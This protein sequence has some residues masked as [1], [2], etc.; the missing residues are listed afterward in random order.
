MDRWLVGLVCSCVIF[1]IVMIDSA[2]SVW[3]L[4]R[5]GD[6]HFFSKRQ[7]IF[8]VAGILMMLFLA[9]YNYW[10][11]KKYAWIVYG[12]GI[13]LLILVLIPGVGLVRNGS[14]SW[15]GVGPLSLQ[16]SEFAKIGVLLLLA[17]NLEES[18]HP[19]THFRKGM[20]PQLLLLLVPF[21]VVM[22]QP[23]L[24]TGTVIL[25]TGLSLLFLAG[26]PYR[27][28]AGLIFLG[29]AGFA[30]LIIS[31]PYRLQRIV[32]YL[33]PWEDPLGAG[34]Q[35]IQSLYAIGPGALFGFGLGESRQK[36]F[37]LPEPQNDFIFA[38][39]GE[40]LGFFGGV[41]LLLLFSAI[42]WR[43]I[44]IALHAPDQFGQL[45]A[46]GIVLMIGIQV[47][48][49]VAVVIGLIPVTGITLPFMSYGGSSLVLVLL[50]CGILLNISKNRKTL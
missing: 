46:G 28:F 31:A 13:L 32:S 39:V 33:D 35:M 17:K 29:I 48:I 30:A 15:L 19:V 43:G 11:W 5:F 21:G 36:Y 24:G 37:Y 38:I 8:A 22:L 23:D 25:G 49:N 26:A 4:D 2:S 7:A 47:M 42:V 9:N 40:E 1:G 14:Q 41:L 12:G 50:S 3:A 27:F 6:A 20:A 16:P 44:I 34:F 18:R 45:L 10:Q